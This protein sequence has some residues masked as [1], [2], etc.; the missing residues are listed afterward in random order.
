V[1]FKHPVK[2]SKAGKLTL[3]P[4]I[5]LDKCTDLESERS[6]IRDREYFHCQNEKSS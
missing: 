3:A 1:L 2:N 4:S 6:V 5:D